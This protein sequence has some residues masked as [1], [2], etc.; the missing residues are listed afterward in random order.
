MQLLYEFQVDVVIVFM[1]WDVEY[2]ILP[3][4]VTPMYDVIENLYEYADVIIGS[5]AHVTQPH[6]YY[7]N[8][9]IAPQMGN[10]LFPMHLSSFFVSLGL[11]SPNSY[12]GMTQ[13]Y[14]EFFNINF[15][16]THYNFT[17]VSLYTLFLTL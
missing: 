10:L 4:R 8:T 17:S 1:H 14:N 11:S 16:C 2:V 9:L 5:H 7:K 12:Y 13:N 3:P 6:F 15:N